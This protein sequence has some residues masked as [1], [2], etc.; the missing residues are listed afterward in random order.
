MHL[1]CFFGELVDISKTP[2]PKNIPGPFDPKMVPGLF[3]GYYLLPGGK[4]GGETF[5][6]MSISHFRKLR[7]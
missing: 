1:G 6:S 5:L 3:A 7:T 2:F 4:W